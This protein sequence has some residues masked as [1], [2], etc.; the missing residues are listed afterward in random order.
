MIHTS[1]AQQAPLTQ[2][3][4]KVQQFVRNVNSTL[5][6]TTPKKQSKVRFL[7]QILKNLKELGLLKNTSEQAPYNAQDAKVTLRKLSVIVDHLLQLK[8]DGKTDDLKTHIE[9]L[10]KSQNFH[11][12]VRL[13]RRILRRFLRRKVRKLAQKIRMMAKQVHQ[14]Q[15]PSAAAT[16]V[17]TPVNKNVKPK[18][19]NRRFPIEKFL[20]RLENLVRSV[21]VASVWKKRFPRRVPKRNQ[22]RRLPR[23]KRAVRRPAAVEHFDFLARLVERL[24]RMEKRRSQRR[25]PRRAPRRVSRNR[26]QRRV[27]RRAP[28]RQEK[29]LFFVHKQLL[30]NVLTTFMRKHSRKPR[31]A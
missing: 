13:V 2:Q 15:Q 23:R 20:K 24:E 29:P 22:K 21:K 16:T 8:K 11:E 26:R 6:A 4:Q 7:R 18:R 30:K 5:S 17:A 14:Q 3:P 12:V 1:F 19:V 25:V 28:R 27:S 9:E 31:R 10:K